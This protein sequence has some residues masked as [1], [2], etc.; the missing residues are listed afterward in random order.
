MGP[1]DQLLIKFLGC[2]SRGGI[3]GVIDP[4]HFGFL[5]HFRLDGSQIRQESI[6]LFKGHRFNYTSGNLYPGD[7]GRIARIRH[8]GDVAMIKHTG[9]NVKKTVGGTQ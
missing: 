5:G 3:V 4:Y 1:I 7:I 2:H 9:V 6:F 8:Q